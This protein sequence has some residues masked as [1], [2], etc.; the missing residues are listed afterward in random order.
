MR[1]PPASAVWSTRGSSARNIVTTPFVSRIAVCTSCTSPRSANPCRRAIALRSGSEIPLVPGVA[2]DKASQTESCP[3]VVLV[4][5]GRGHRHLGLSNG[6]PSGDSA[7]GAGAARGVRLRIRRRGPGLLDPS[8]E[9]SELD[10][11]SR[12]APG[13]SAA[14]SDCLRSC[15]LLTRRSRISP[16]ESISRVMGSESLRLAASCHKLHA[17]PTRPRAG[18]GRLA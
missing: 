12:C 10:P 13:I 16:V 7:Y 8:R 11:T 2:R 14:R 5:A 9:A 3:P 6:L 1:R 15:A 18:S 4:L 17:F